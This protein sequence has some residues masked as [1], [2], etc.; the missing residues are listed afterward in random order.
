M[1]TP[2]RA[3][4]A[5]T[6]S[7]CVLLP[8]MRTVH[9]RLCCGSRRSASSNAEAMTAGMSSVTDAVSHLP[10]A[11]GSRGFPRPLAFPACAFFFFFFLLLYCA[12]VLMIS[13]GV[14]GTGAAS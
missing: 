3:A 8:S 7:I 10:R 1:V 5:A 2:R 9:S 12:G 14:R 13:S 6:A 11:C 4:S